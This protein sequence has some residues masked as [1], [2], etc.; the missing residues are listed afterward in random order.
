MQQINFLM[1]IVVAAMATVTT[2]AAQ[3][4]DFISCSL[5]VRLLDQYIEEKVNSILADEPGML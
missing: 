4:G 3:T 1:F 2:T 5:N